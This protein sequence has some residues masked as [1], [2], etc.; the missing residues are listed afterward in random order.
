M[1]CL[2]ADVTEIEVGH[3]ADEPRTALI[4]VSGLHSADRTARRK[5]LLKVNPA[6]PLTPKPLLMPGSC[7]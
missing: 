4:V 7:A 3:Y 5:V 1:A 2:V 6:T